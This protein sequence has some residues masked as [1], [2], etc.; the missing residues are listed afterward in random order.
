VAKERL[1]VMLKNSYGPEA[2]MHEEFGQP[3]LAAAAD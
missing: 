1:R 3:G 2:G